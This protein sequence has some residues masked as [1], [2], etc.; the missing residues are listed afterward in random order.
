V[1]VEELRVLVGE[2]VV[3][4]QCSNAGKPCPDVQRGR[5]RMLP[6]TR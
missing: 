2:A 5:P 4:A 1:R 6:G 3:Q